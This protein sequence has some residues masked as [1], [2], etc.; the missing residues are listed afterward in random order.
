MIVIKGKIH[1]TLKTYPFSLAHFQVWYYL[2]GHF[3]YY[4][5]TYS[6]SENLPFRKKGYSQYGSG[7]FK[8]M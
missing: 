8:V 7:F 3:T 1:P 4:L 5:P 6:F 2:I